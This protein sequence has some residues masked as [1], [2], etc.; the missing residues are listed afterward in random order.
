[1]ASQLGDSGYCYYRPV[2]GDGNCYFRA[3]GIAYFEQLLVERH[4]YALR[5]LRNLVLYDEQHYDMVS[6][7]SE[8]RVCL[9][10]PVPTTKLK[11]IFCSFLEILLQFI[12]ENKRD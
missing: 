7:L 6:F 9:E 4:H 12:D 2:R 1:M 10:E 3:V 5:D 8:A 11:E